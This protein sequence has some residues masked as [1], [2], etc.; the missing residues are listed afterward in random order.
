MDISKAAAAYQ[1]VSGMGGIK[2]DPVKFDNPD[3]GAQTGPAFLD[4]VAEG[5]ESARSTGYNSEATSAEALA[6]KAELH[7]LVS[8][9]SNA[10]LTLNT[11]VAVRDRMISAYQDIIKMPI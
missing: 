6:N 3:E 5:L 4:L 8:A 1:N 11:V 10:E 9:V 2:A 7:D